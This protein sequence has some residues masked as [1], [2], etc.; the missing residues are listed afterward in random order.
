MIFHSVEET[1]KRL[2]NMAK[3]RNVRVF[4]VKKEEAGIRNGA[5]YIAPELAFLEENLFY[6]AD[7][8]Y[9]KAADHITICESQSLFEECEW[10][11]ATIRKLL[12][13]D[14]LRARDIAVIVRNEEDYKKELLGAFRRYDIPFFDDARQPVENQPLVV[15]CRT[16]LSLLAQGFTSENLLQ[17]LKTGLA[18]V[19]PEEVAELEN[20]IFTWDVKGR[21][22]QDPFPWNPFGLDA[23]FRSEA[24]AD[25]A[26]ATAA[27]LPL[28]RIAHTIKGNALA[29]GD[30]KMGQTAIDL[31]GAAQLQDLTLATALVAQLKELAATL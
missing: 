12:R 19:G 31:R 1:K 22:W 6:P 20:Y 5:R 10:I 9:D 23:N 24:E 21:S 27:W 15:L 11:A 17:Y 7:R 4:E 26:L 14:G 2:E 3:E 28:D 30:E 25:E 29:V 13:E 18:G 16:V 8:V